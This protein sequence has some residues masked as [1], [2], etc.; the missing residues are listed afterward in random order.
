MDAGVMLVVA[1]MAIPDPLRPRMAATEASAVASL[2]TINTAQITYGMAY[3]ERGFATTLTKLGPNPAQAQKPTEDHAGLMD[4]SLA[5][6]H[7]TADGWCTKSGYRFHLEGV[8][9]T[10]PCKEYV[11]TATPVANSTAGVRNFCSTSDGRIR[12]QPTSG[13][14]TTALTVVECKKWEPLR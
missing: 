11:V 10:K 8:C 2:R 14:L 9:K 6:D 12:I 3:P 1:A 5:G 13:T 7:C 4:E